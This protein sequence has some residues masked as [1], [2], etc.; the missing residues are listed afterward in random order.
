MKYPSFLN[1]ENN[2][3]KLSEGIKNTVIFDNFD[4]WFNKIDNCSNWL[5]F[6]L[7]NELWLNL[8]IYLIF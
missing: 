5:I 2:C 6:K 7:S 8:Y 1:Q 4:D 3:S